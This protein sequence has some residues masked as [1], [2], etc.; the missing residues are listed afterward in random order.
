MELLDRQK[1]CL[2][3]RR[4]GRNHSKAKRDAPVV[5]SE[6]APTAAQA[7]LADE[8]SLAPTMPTLI[9]LLEQ[10]R[11]GMGMGRMGRT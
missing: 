2:L 9:S 4:S 3:S 7:Q 8:E 1:L 5:V 6:T 11:G 10:V